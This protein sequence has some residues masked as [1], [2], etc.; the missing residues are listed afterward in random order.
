LLGGE[1]GRE[2][3]RGRRAR[4]TMMMRVTRHAVCLL[5]CCVVSHDSGQQCASLLRDLLRSRVS[6]CGHRRSRFESAR[7]SWSRESLTSQSCKSAQ[8]RL[9]LALPNCSFDDGKHSIYLPVFVYDRIVSTGGWRELH[10]KN[11][12]ERNL[13]CTKIEH[14]VPYTPSVLFPLIDF[15]FSSA[16]PYA[17]AARKETAASWAL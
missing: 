3:G 4:P 14:T 12:C 15:Y 11:R 16:T 8:V 7:P 13:P 2:R 6:Y 17:H 5:G 10:F 9:P 1:D